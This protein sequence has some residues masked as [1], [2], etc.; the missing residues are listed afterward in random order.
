MVM[1]TDETKNPN[2]AD[3]P[4]SQV[5]LVLKDKRK[6][7]EYHVVFKIRRLLTGKAV[8]QKNYGQ[9]I[10]QMSSISDLKRPMCPKLLKSLNTMMQMHCVQIFQYF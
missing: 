8:P 2:F 5:K 7:P 6:N 4:M 10:L 3:W 9:T 1:T